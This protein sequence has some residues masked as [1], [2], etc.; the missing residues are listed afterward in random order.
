MSKN[1]VI[2]LINI[3][4]CYISIEKDSVYGSDTRKLGNVRPYIN[5]NRIDITNN[6]K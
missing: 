5:N 6:D 4:H 2:D 3:D 1:I